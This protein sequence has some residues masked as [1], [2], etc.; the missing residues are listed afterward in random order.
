MNKKRIVISIISIIIVLALTVIGYE[1]INSRKVY[2]A[3]SSYPA[4]GIVKSISVNIYGKDDAGIIFSKEYQTQ[5]GFLVDII[6]EIPDAK[7]IV[8]DGPYGAYIT[9][10]M[11]IEQGDGYY[12]SYY[13]NG[14]YATE[15]ISSCEIEDNTVYDF[16]IEKFQ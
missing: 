7:I 10:I 12:W 3:T 16:K 5:K 8:E 2:E 9:S 6:A 14:N 15:G 1:Y 4:V 11:D 13:I